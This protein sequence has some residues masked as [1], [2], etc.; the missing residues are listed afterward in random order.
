MPYTVR[1]HIFGA[2]AALV[3]TG[4]APTL[5][6]LW[7]PNDIK[8]TLPAES[9]FNAALAYLKHKIHNDTVTSNADR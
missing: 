9:L 8:T 6:N 1:C 5:S 4:V 2:K 3:Q 7:P